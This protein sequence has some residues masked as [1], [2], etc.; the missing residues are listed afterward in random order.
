MAPAPGE[1]LDLAL[2][3]PYCK[4]SHAA[5]A[6]GYAAASRHRVVLH[7]LPG[8]HWKWR[9]CHAPLTLARRLAG[10]GPPPR[11]LLCTS[12]VDLAALRGLLP[13]DRPR[14]PAALYFHE[15]QLTYP[16][17]PGEKRD[18]HYAWIQLVSCLAAEAVVFN[19]AFH[20]ED[21]LGALP[22]FLRS[23]PDHA[24]TLRSTGIEEKCTVVP[25]GI[26]W[27]LFAAAAAAAGA[28]R[29]GPLRVLWNHR[30]EADKDPLAFLDVL[31][32]L[33]EGGRPFAAVLAGAGADRPGPAAAARIDRLGGRVVHRG[34]APADGYPDLVASCDVV[35]STARHD[36]YGISTVEAMAAGVLPLLP[37][38]QNYPRLLPPSHREVCLHAGPEELLARLEAF[39]ADPAAARRLAAPLGAHVRDQDRAAAAAVLDDLLERL[40]LSPPPPRS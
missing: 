35:V 36:F 23:F 20:R 15:N 2:L 22:A 28:S 11:A 7:E 12:M 8:I 39:A 24:P 18:L 26:D 31:L 25:P 10:A 32:R 9:M 40:A 13:P 38:R 21:F 14:P 29:Q 33:A 27:R 6:R 30:W 17:A 1:P 19:S 37:A 3:E 16:L 4:G 5:W 34:R